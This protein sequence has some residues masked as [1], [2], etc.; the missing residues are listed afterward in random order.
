MLFF[1]NAFPM[2]LKNGR[3]FLG[4]GVDF[5]LIVTHGVESGGLSWGQT[6]ELQQDTIFGSFLSSGEL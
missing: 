6:F 1:E 3:N 2:L 5:A 4:R